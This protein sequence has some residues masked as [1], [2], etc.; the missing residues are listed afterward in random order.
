MNPL[1]I[2]EAGPKAQTPPVAPD[3]AEM[4]PGAPAFVTL[5]E[6]QVEPLTVEAETQNL[7]IATDETIELPV[8]EDAKPPPLT[9]EPTAIQI[10]LPENAKVRA[11]V[12]GDLVINIKNPQAASALL[13]GKPAKVAL[14]QD[15]QEVTAIRERENQNG[16]KQPLP[17]SAASAQTIVVARGLAA[18]PA[19]GVP[20]A[21]E[22]GADDVAVERSP[23]HATKT[24]P[25][26]PSAAV[27]LTR[28]EARPQL[29]PSPANASQSA[30]VSL[31]SPRKESEVDPRPSPGEPK[32]PSANAQAPVL[33]AAATLQTGMTNPKAFA[34]QV[35]EIE[36]TL[37]RGASETGQN[38][39]SEGRTVASV[40]ASGATTP[41][42]TQAARQV[43]Q[44]ISTAISAAQGRATEI[45]LN[46]EELGRVKMTLTASEGA[47]TLVLLADR[48]ETND[49]LRRHIDALAQ[50][51]RAIGY[52][53]ISFSFGSDGQPRNSDGQDELSE[54]NDLAVQSVEPPKGASGQ[55]TTGLDLR[56]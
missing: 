14:V 6:G 21:V 32:A 9:A 13:E 51:F 50:E 36:K 37:P 48:P 3:D 23:Q 34:R 49:L 44:Q 26:G 43:A 16:P 39:L 33:P 10:V 12:S 7:A 19:R 8:T 54:R 56:V 30:P 42:S 52:D 24:E 45:A 27:T 17:S 47:V 53:S 55:L 35:E 15:G 25:K 29:T 40:S 2:L 28:N 4:P 11:A 5:V 31:P 1:H 46:P 22:P 41:T 18:P 20:I 38:A